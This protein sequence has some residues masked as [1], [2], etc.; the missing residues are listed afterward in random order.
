MKDKKKKHL[1]NEEI[2]QSQVRV[3][4]VGLLSIGEALEMAKSQDMD[5]VL[6]NIDNNDIAIC[7]IMKYEKY[8]YELNKA[9]KQKKIEVKEIKIGPNTSDNDLNYR[10]NHVTEFL[11]KGHKV[12]LTMEF[13]G[14]EM[15][16]I[17]KGNA[18]F[19]NLLVKLEEVAVPE[20]LPKIEGKKLY[21]MLRPKTK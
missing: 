8:I 16:Y 17:E 20:F 9:N 14:R 1:I 13:R 2:R 6:F 10:I 15:N 12:K 18:L 21:T 11:K 3:T 4:D 7:K 19:L 5:L